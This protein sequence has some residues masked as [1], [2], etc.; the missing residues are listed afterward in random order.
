M[1]TVNCYSIAP[2]SLNQTF[3]PNYNK[4]ATLQSSLTSVCEYPHENSIIIIIIITSYHSGC[5]DFRI[6]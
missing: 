1:S 6:P 4:I 3:N 2:V 5:H